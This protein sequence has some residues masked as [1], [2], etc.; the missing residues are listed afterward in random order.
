MESF[1]STAIR[2]YTLTINFMQMPGYSHNMHKA[3]LR[4]EYLLDDVLGDSTLHIK[5]NDNLSSRVAAELST[6]LSAA[7][8]DDT[9][10]F[11]TASPEAFPLTYAFV[12]EQSDILTSDTMGTPYVELD[13]PGD[14]LSKVQEFISLEEL[15]GCAYT[16]TLVIQTIVLYNIVNC[17]LGKNGNDLFNKDLWLEHIR[18][19]VQQE[20]RAFIDY[21]MTSL[22]TDGDVVAN[23]LQTIIKRMPRS[24]FIT[25]MIEWVNSER[26]KSSQ[27]VT[28]L[29]VLDNLKFKGATCD[30]ETIEILKTN[31][32]RFE[33]I[34]YDKQD[35]IMN[36]ANFMCVDHSL[37]IIE[38]DSNLR[39]IIYLILL[40]MASSGLLEP[41]V[42]N[43]RKALSK[44]K[45]A[46]DLMSVLNTTINA[47][48][49]DDTCITFAGGVSTGLTEFVVKESQSVHSNS[50]SASAF[51]RITEFINQLGLDKLPLEKKW[52]MESIMTFNILIRTPANVLRDQIYGANFFFAKMMFMAKHENNK[53]VDLVQCF[54]NDNSGEINIGEA[55]IETLLS[56]LSE[57]KYLCQKVDLLKKYASPNTNIVTE[58]RGNLKGKRLGEN[59]ETDIK[60]FVKM[61]Y[62]AH[63]HL[64]SKI[65]NISENVIKYWVTFKIFV[66]TE[67][68]E[69]EYRNDAGGQLVDTGGVSTVTG[70]PYRLYNTSLFIDNINTELQTPD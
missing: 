40:H 44:Y 27:V 4:M 42:V 46:R 32:L 67:R 43:L 57:I 62:T 41:T 3:F 70:K 64:S 54:I 63:P 37:C 9:T 30:A 47:D 10:G 51:N 21:V 36:I 8:R 60:D 19:M 39:D 33:N 26:I 59:T 35:Y 45:S 23:M 65:V 22:D 34:D 7:K 50:L 48:H 69:H 25:N 1:V 53:L 24:N 2:I 66:R 31:A 14:I 11:T 12:L 55:V 13:L 58:A 20:Q 52:I 15:N 28:F 5:S 61:V 56:R 68:Y 17:F 29:R 6:L 38:E 16:D 49:A 18:F